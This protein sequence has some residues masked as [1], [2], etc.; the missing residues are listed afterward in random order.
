MSNAKHIANKNVPDNFEKAI[1]HIQLLK[2]ESSSFAVGEP[3][4]LGP[5]CS[6]SLR[7]HFFRKLPIFYL[8]FLIIQEPSTSS[9]VDSEQAK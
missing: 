6:P 7:I 2:M 4:E 8:P 3:A 5:S 9:P 1:V